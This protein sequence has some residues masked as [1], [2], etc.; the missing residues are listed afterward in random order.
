[1]HILYG[2]Y[3]TFEVVEDDEGLSLGFEVR[4]RDD[5]DYTAVFA[6]DLGEGFGQFWDFN[7]LF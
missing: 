6:E 1:M 5:V 4:F 3:G 2:T 7:A